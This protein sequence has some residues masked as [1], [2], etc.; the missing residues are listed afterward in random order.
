M[1]LPWN[2]QSPKDPMLRQ[3]DA[4]R[5]L[6]SYGKPM[7]DQAPGG[8]CEPVGNPCWSSLDLKNCTLWKGA[9]LETILKNC[10]SVGEGYVLDT[11]VRDCLL[12]VGL[13]NAAGEDIEKERSSRDNTGRISCNPLF[14]IPLSC[15][16][17]GSREFKGEVEPN[18]KGKVG[19]R[20]L[21]VWFSFS[22][23]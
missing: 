7:E 5:K 3:M 10:S 6:W 15:S 17:G 16:W 19:E 18:K 21:K 2:L 1:E 11:F 14:P 4:W 22:L 9:M 13:H 8:T 23:P 20:Y 12:W